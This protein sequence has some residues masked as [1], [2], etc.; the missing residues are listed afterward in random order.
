M[1]NIP[2]AAAIIFLAVGG[3][4]IWQQQTHYTTY[5][6]EHFEVS[7]RYPTEYSLTENPLHA[8]GPEEWMTVELHGPYDITYFFG[9]RGTEGYCFGMDQYSEK[10][11]LL[12]GK[13]YKEVV[14]SMTNTPAICAYIRLLTLNKVPLRFDQAHID[15]RGTNIPAALAA[16]EE[17]VGTTHYQ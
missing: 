14:A 8:V 7:F 12:Q 17:I 6:N 5:H 15:Y 1:K 3:F 4:L 2:L 11:I 16:F 10:M 13:K 9:E